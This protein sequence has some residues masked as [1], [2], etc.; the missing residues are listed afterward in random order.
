MRLDDRTV[1]ILQNYSTIN[2]NI[3]C[4]AGGTI[5]TM[6][7]G[8]SVVARAKLDAPIEREFAIN[9]LPRFLG[10]VRLFRD[11]KVVIDEK[12]I[13]L[14]EGDKR[15][16]YTLTSPSD[17]KIVPTPTKDIAIDV[18]ATFRMTTKLLKEIKDAAAALG[19]RQI[20]MVGDGG[21]IYVETLDTQNPTSDKY[22]T[23]VGDTDKD[24]SLVVNIDNLRL[25]QTD[26]DV[27]LSFR[28]IVKF[29]GEG[30]EYFVAVEQ[31]QSVV[32]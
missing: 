29:R 5:S 19:H 12:S 2:R 22:R 8:M 27:D 15:V 11:P 17:P 18:A 20:A 4:R 28:G 30:I 6:T 7:D 26:Y 10:V 14:T 21:H 25:I 3:L 32:P 1:Q 13:V 31:K 23:K 24:F 9:D 16:S